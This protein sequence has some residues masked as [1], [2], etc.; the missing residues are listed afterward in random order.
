MDASR[1]TRF[2]YVSLL[3]G[4]LVLVLGSLSLFGWVFDVPA[5]TRIHPSWKPMVPGTALCFVLSGV[6]LLISRQPVRRSVLVAQSLLLWLIL[7]LAGTRAV[8]LVSGHSLGIEFLLPVLSIQPAD[9]GHMSP[10]TT[11]GFLLFVIGMLTIQRSDG[12][13]ARILAGLMAGALLIIGAGAIIGYWLNFQHVFEALYA[14]T[15]LVWMA[16]TTATGM[17]LLGLGLLC[18]TLMCGQRSDASTVEQKAAR[19]YRTTLWV[20]SAT[21]VA[22]GHFALPFRAS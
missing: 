8:E 13:S 6:S 5:L 9:S 21:A 10:Q 1:S 7:L 12:R 4:L 22:T 16:F 20:L 2:N 19:I 3:P 17:F 11:T 15:G 14:R 18:R